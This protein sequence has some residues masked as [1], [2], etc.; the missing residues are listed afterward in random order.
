MVIKET[1]KKKGGYDKLKPI[2]EA[3]MANQKEAKQQLNK[4]GYTYDKQLSTNESKVFIDKEGNPN[5][6]FRGSKRIKDFLISDP[7][8]AVG[9]QNLDPRYKEA[10]A[11]TKKVEQKYNKPADTFGFSLGGDIASKSGAKGSIITYNKGTGLGDIGKIVPEN[12]LDIRTKTDRVSALNLVQRHPYDNLINLNTPLN[13]SLLEA[14][15]IKNIP[16]NFIV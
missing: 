10:K 9:L 2:L 1:F 6:A 4:L 15:D 3:S 7:L 12:Q 13:Q 11:L 5:I 14:H 8:L 16:T